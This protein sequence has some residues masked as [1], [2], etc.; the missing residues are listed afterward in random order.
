MKKLE[1]TF[2]LSI[3]AL[4][5]GITHG[6]DSEAL[7]TGNVGQINPTNPQVLTGNIQV[8]G[9][10]NSTKLTL[11]LVLPNG[12]QQT[13]SNITISENGTYNIFELINSTNL[14]Q[15][16]A[17][18]NVT[19]EN[20]IPKENLKVDVS[21]MDYDEANTG[22]VSP[23]PNGNASASA[24]NRV[25]GT[26]STETDEEDP[27]TSQNQ[28]IGGSLAT[29]G[30]SAFLTNTQESADLPTTSASNSTEQ[31]TYDANG[32]V[33]GVTG[34][35]LTRDGEG[36]TTAF[37]Q[38]ATDAAIT[39][40][41]LDELKELFGAKTNEQWQT[42]DWNSSITQ[43]AL[44]YLLAV[45][46]GQITSGISITAVQAKAIRQA[47][48]ARLS[49]VNR[50]FINGCL[51]GYDLN[52]SNINLQYADW[53]GRLKDL[54]GAMIVQAASSIQNVSGKDA[55]IQGA[56]FEQVVWT[57]TENV[58]NMSLAFVFTGGFVGI[59]NAQMT[60]IDANPSGT[61]GIVM[62]QE[63]NEA[64]NGAIPNCPMSMTWGGYDYWD[65]IFDQLWYYA[66]FVGGDPKQYRYLV[67]WQNLEN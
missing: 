8:S 53:R 27:G 46:K 26:S 25:A 34:R 32:M 62:T 37:T 24:S 58:S 5:S 56:Y 39:E 55:G 64:W 9:I 35:T 21:L 67:F 12:T 51:S 42:F 52:F 45:H 4:L 11:D 60:A 54:T 30:D 23:S 65:N 43:A 36:S 15:G 22:N 7:Y 66:S 20:A 59:T 3:I 40:A 17:Q 1:R 28:T 29:V 50:S 47:L 48:L 61:L 49:Y 41:Q 63:Q 13:I 2:I 57:G 44:D 6:A 16:A 33:I 10:T 18:L 38:T 14:P 19:S 31:I